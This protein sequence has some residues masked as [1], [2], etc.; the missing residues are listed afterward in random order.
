MILEE[1]RAAFSSWR[2]AKRYNSETIPDVLWGL[3]QS[4]FERHSRREICNTLKINPRQ[5]DLRCGARKMLP[6]SA[7]DHA[8]VSLQVP[9]ELCSTEGFCEVV[10]QGERRKLSIHVSEDGLKKILPLLQECL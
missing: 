7:S 10:L 3:V 5:F 8:F 9:E 6:E 1:V 4:L 2:V